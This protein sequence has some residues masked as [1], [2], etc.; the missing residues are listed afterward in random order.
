MP[1]LFV[2]PRN[3]P[4]QNT[5]ISDPEFGEITVMR[6]HSR[7]VRLR[8]L[9]NGKLSVTMPYYATLMSV[10]SLLEKN[11]KTLRKNIA[12]MPKSKTFTDAEKA[13][14]RKKARKYFNL[15]LMEL[16]R[17]HGF[18]FTKLRLSSARTRWG[19]CSTNGTVSLNIA[20]MTVPKHLQDYVILHELTHTEHMNHSANFWARVES[21]CPKYKACR[22][23]LKK[24]SP[25]I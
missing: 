3:H 19:S 15:R 6:T 18:R 22:K 2:K 16:A 13:D 7:Y 25:L 23:E 21:T 4:K 12:N 1:F 5:T 10:K 14:L 11:R 8:V 9:P 24:Y 17:E 20:L